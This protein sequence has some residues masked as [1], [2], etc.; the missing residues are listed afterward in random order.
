MNS[1][2]L[3]VLTL[4]VPSPLYFPPLQ[5]GGEVDGEDSMH[6]IKLISTVGLLIFQAFSKRSVLPN[7]T[8]APVKQWRQISSYD[9]KP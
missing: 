5:I 3:L 7:V 4:S 2:R 6:A 8:A 1:L 9:V